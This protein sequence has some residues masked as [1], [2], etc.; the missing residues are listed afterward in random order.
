[1]L[2]AIGKLRH[3]LAA[4]LAERVLRK[5]DATRFGDAFEPGRDVD[6]V[7]QDIVALDQHIAE[8]NPDAPFHALVAGDCRIALCRQ[9]LKHDG[10]FDCADHRGELDQHAITGGL[11]DPP[12]MLDNERVGGGAMLAQCPCRAGFVLAH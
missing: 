3:D 7:A 6:A 12:A 5:A 11:D 8:M 4:H 1:V 2:A 9:P 10:A